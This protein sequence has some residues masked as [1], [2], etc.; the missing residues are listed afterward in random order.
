MATISLC[1]RCRSGRRDEQRSL[2][3]P[4]K[5]IAGAAVLL[6]LALSA[7]RVSTS[8]APAGRR[9][10]W[11]GA[12]TAEQAERGDRQLV[13][14]CS[15]CHGSDFHGGPGAQGIVGPEFL[16]SWNQKSAAELFEYVQTT[17]PPGQAG[18]LSD[19]QYA[20][21]LAAIFKRNG[22]PA[23]AQTSLEPRK[24]SLEQV[25]ILREKP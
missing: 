17:M 25:I 15:M 1:S 14:Q 8:Q 22:F 7:A 12:Y 2:G 20:D 6:A 10:V 4:V 11:D 9:T 5:R 3:E 21:V 23:A 24:D 19:D 13:Y 16:F 18:S